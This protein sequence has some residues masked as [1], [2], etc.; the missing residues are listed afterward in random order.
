MDMKEPGPRFWNTISFLAS[1]IGLALSIAAI[2]LRNDVT[3]GMGHILGCGIGATPAC[4]N[5]ALSSWAAPFFGISLGAFGA[6]F[7]L[8]NGIWLVFETHSSERAYIARIAFFVSLVLLAYSAF[9][10]KSFCSYCTGIDVVLLLLAIVAR[11]SGKP[12]SVRRLILSGAMFG[13]VL[14]ALAAG[15]E[16]GLF[17]ILKSQRGWSNAPLEFDWAQLEMADKVPDTQIASIPFGDS[18][19]QVTL[20]FFGD[21][22]CHFCQE[23]F[24]HLEEASEISGI[25]LQGYFHPFPQEES[26]NPGF[27]ADGHSGA[28]LAAKIA[29]CSLGRPD[30]KSIFHFLFESPGMIQANVKETLFYIEANGP[31]YSGLGTC[32]ES[33]VTQKKLDDAIRLSREFDVRVTPTMIIGNRMILGSPNRRDWIKILQKARE[34]EI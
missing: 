4:A 22:K 13:A 26:C 1:M 34:T 28:C 9:I 15:V 29:L 14:L 21:F 20:H 12:I 33:D 2:V 23:T 18:Q 16:R 32:V 11:K 31:K 24:K 8:L 6:S 25:K 5:V 10:I 3:L 7:F 27:G 30:Q 17:S 19:A